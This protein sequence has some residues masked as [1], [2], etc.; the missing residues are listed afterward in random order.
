MPETNCARKGIK[1]NTY[2]ALGA[3]VLLMP[4]IRASAL[5]SAMYCCATLMSWYV[6]FERNRSAALF[7]KLFVLFVVG[8]ENACGP[9]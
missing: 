1:S 5:L 4:V 6:I 2:A 8:T 9:R 7:A 3:I